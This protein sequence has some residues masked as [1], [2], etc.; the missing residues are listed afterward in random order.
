MRCYIVGTSVRK[1]LCPFTS[2]VLFLLFQYLFVYSARMHR[3]LR[4]RS[5]GAKATSQLYSSKKNK[6]GDTCCA[7]RICRSEFRHIS[8]VL[9]HVTHLKYTAVPEVPDSIS[10]RLSL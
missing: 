9:N 2:T 10:G 7:L 8:R 3:L 6:I 4:T 1:A 5:K